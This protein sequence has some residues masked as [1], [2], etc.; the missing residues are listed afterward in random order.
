MSH[1]LSLLRPVHSWWNALGSDSGFL[2]RAKFCLFAPL[3]RGSA[4]FDKKTAL[5]TNLPSLC[6]GIATC[7]F[8]DTERLP[9]VSLY[10]RMAIPLAVAPEV[11]Y[12]VCGITD[13]ER[14]DD[15]RQLQGVRSI[16]SI[17]RTSSWRIVA[18]FDA[19]SVYRMHENRPNRIPTPEE[20]GASITRKTLFNYEGKPEW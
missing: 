14:E 1:P 10:A 3:A 20:L 6:G 2:K 11:Y 7:L 5:T 9:Y 17:G 19:G 13:P 8:D 18:D 15:P 12:A 16:L 4:V